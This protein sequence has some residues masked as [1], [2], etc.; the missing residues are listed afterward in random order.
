ML[1]GEE[2]LEQKDDHVP[3]LVA[4]VHYHQD[5]CMPVLLAVLV[6]YVLA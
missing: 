1:R 5:R 4:L 2:N 6:N 3:P